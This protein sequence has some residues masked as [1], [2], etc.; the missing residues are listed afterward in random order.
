MTR[1]QF[2]E[3][4]KGELNRGHV[5]DADDILEEYEQHFAFKLAD[6]YGEEEVAARL[7]DPKAIAAQY[8]AAPDKKQGGSRGLVYI[9][10]GFI[11]LF[12]G[13]MLILLCAWEVVMAA[14]TLGCGAVALGLL[15]NL[16]NAVWSLI[17]AMPYLCGLPLGL[18]CAGLT[19]L[20]AVGTVYF[21]AFIR[22]LTRAFGRFHR[23]T[24][25]SAAGRAALPPL[26]AYP[27]FSAKARR[28]LRRLFLI[29]LTVF[30]ACFLL[31]FVACA[32]SAG[33]IEFWHVWH[34]FS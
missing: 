18:A 34:W 3:Q 4:L 23:N 30:A 22:Q 19:V 14:L 7:G 11:D 10:L 9:G 2:I 28:K 29:A 13:L 31:G 12:F 21:S 16:R 17:P 33:S 25:A 27:Q 15:A 5:A 20:A 8:E 32:L 1:Q 6:G 24:L 26:A